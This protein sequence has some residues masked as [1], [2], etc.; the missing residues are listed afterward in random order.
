VKAVN[1]QQIE[2]GLIFHSRTVFLTFVSD[3][4]EEEFKNS[5][6]KPEID[7]RPLAEVLLQEGLV[8][9][10]LDQAIYGSLSEDEMDDIL[11]LL[12]SRMWF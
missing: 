9:P 11:T 4:L 8:A 7:Y 6:E 10:G 12:S 2:A 3:M 5:E 1:L